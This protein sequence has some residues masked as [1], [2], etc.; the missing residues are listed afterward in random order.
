MKISSRVAFLFS[1]ILCLVLGFSFT[2]CVDEN[3]YTNSP[4]VELKFSA[5]TLTFDTVFTTISSITQTLMVYNHEN[6]LVLLL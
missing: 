2:S 1:L 4:A 5:D 3:E 6:Q